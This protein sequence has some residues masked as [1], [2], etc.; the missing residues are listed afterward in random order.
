MPRVAMAYTG[1]LRTF[2]PRWSHAN[3]MRMLVDHPAAIFH[4]FDADIFFVG[5]SDGWFTGSARHE[6]F[7]IPSLKRVL[8]YHDRFTFDGGSER[9]R[10]ATLGAVQLIVPTL[11]LLTTRHGRNNSALVEEW[12]D[13]LLRT[14]NLDS[15]NSFAWQAVHCRAAFDAILANELASG[16]RYDAVARLRWDVVAIAP[17]AMPAEA[18][19]AASDPAHTLIAH[20]TRNGDLVFHS[21]RLAL[22][23]LHGQAGS[24]LAMPPPPYGVVHASHAKAAGVTRIAAG[25]MGGQLLLMRIHRMRRCVRFD[26]LGSRLP[27]PWMAAHGRCW[28]GDPLCMEHAL[29]H[30][31][32]MHAPAPPSTTSSHHASE[33]RSEAKAKQQEE[34][35]PS[36][37]MELGAGH[38]DPSRLPPWQQGGR[39]S[40]RPVAAGSDAVGWFVNVAAERSSWCERCASDR[41]LH[42]L[43]AA[44]TAHG[45][46]AHRGSADLDGAHS[47]RLCPNEG[48]IGLNNVGPRNQTELAWWRERLA[49]LQPGERIGLARLAVGSGGDLDER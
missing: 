26:T 32:C 2:S 4:K 48:G 7:A 14:R 36:N 17:F 5:P 8:L 18:F 35:K 24:P 45:W 42:D 27:P 30:S 21:G 16:F 3:N 44:L 13:G 15:F 1:Q 39:V 41:L 38:G 23:L 31:C 33:G 43:V 25:P 28:R 10:S 29:E 34:E 6:L 12:M 22:D 40:A 47:H 19:A 20:D 11:P 9:A 46:S 37:Q 49:A